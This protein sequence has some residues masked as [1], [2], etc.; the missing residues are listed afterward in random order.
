M[1][2]SRVYRGRL[3]RDFPQH[4]AFGKFLMQQVEKLPIV[5]TNNPET[6]SFTKEAWIRIVQQFQ[7]GMPVTFALEEQKCWPL[8]FTAARG[9]PTIHIKITSDAIDKRI[10]AHR[11]IYKLYHP[12]E[13]LIL[14]DRTRQVSHLCGNCRCANP[15]HM[16]IE[17]DKTNKSRNY[18][19]HGSVNLCPHVPKCEF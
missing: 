10:A 6:F 12:E 15:K 13:H 3:P 19:R 17:D 14:G 9:Y 5:S 8:S 16:L 18:C 2:A 4:S 1:S 7:H 11:L